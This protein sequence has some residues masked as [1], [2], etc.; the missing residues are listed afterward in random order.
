M[1]SFNLLSVFRF[2]YKETKVTAK[3]VNG[4]AMSKFMHPT[5]EKQTFIPLS[6]HT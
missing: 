6:L 3:S 5:L 2:R 4:M 1:V